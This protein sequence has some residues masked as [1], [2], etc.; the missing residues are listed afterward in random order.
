MANEIQ[1][2]HTATGENLYITIRNADGQYWNGSAF[3]AFVVGNWDDYDITLAETPAGGYRYEADFPAGISGEGNYSIDAYKRAGASPAISDELLASCEF[4]WDGTSEVILPGLADVID[5]ELTTTHGS[6][7]WSTGA[8]F[9]DVEVDHNY[10]GTDSLRYT[11]NA[12]G[13]DGGIIRAYLK[14]EYDAGTRVIRGQA[15][16]GSDGRWIAPMY[17]DADDYYLF[18]S[19]PGVHSATKVE[20]TVS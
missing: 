8:G 14:D 16:T 13:V 20:V 17:L 12:A 10:G 4:A 19:K 18:F 1:Y 5:A 9:G 15:A 11:H 3:E 2:R 6:G 7:S